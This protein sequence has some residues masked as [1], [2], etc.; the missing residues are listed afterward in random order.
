MD[1]RRDIEP[2]AGEDGAQGQDPD[3]AIFSTVRV[4][5]PLRA[6]LAAAALILTVGG[7]VLAGAVGGQ[8]RTRGGPSTSAPAL[9]A[10]STPPLTP[11]ARVRASVTPVPPL[12]AL[13][14]HR[15]GGYLF[16]HGDIS[17]WTAIAVIVSIRD[18]SGNTLAI[19]TVDMPGGSAALALGPVSRFYVAFRVPAEGGRATSVQANAYDR[20]GKRIASLEQQLE[21]GAL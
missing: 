17:T 15:D 8:S 19:E 4:R 13:D 10:A 5:A 21:A 20:T 14:S 6:P 18:A 16:V 3:E 1:D 9:A 12:M 11:H 7:I 2:G